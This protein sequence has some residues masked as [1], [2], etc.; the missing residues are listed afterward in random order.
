MKIVKY[1][2]MNNTLLQYILSN[3]TDKQINNLIFNIAK[4]SK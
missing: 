1:N 3:I 4:A 2:V